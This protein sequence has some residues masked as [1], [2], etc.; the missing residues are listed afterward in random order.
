MSSML[1]PTDVAPIFETHTVVYRGEPAVLFAAS[2]AWT[3]HV[4]VRLEKETVE[5]LARARGM[6]EVDRYLRNVPEAD[7]PLVVYGADCASVEFNGIG[8]TSGVVESPRQDWLDLADSS[9]RILAFL[10]VPGEHQEVDLRKQLGS[11]RGFGARLRTVRIPEAPEPQRY[12]FLGP[13]SFETPIGGQHSLLLDSNV[14]IDM[15]SVARGRVAP[16]STLAREVQRIVLTA[17]HV[18]TIPGLAIFELCH[19]RTTGRLNVK[20][21]TELR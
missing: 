4:V 12:Q 18:D 21:A 20:R 6:V 2:A 19:D 15:E 14:L 7:G 8:L 17:V 3:G 11:H 10:V 1:R 13:T 5:R 16:D 9:E